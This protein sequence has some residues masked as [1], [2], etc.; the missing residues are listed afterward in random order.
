MAAVS[1]TRS[2]REAGYPQLD[3]LKMTLPK[4]P[5]IRDGNLSDTSVL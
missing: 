3:A 1:D 2:W 5:L 4:G